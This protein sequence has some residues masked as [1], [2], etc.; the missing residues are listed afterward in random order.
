M[1]KKIEIIHDM[2]G[3][4]RVVGDEHL[5]HCPFCNHHKKKMSI[6]FGLNMFK[7]WVCDT[8][9]KN[10]YRLVRQFGTYQQRQ[11]WLQLD[12]RLDISEFDKFFSEVN[13]EVESHTIEPPESFISLCNRHLPRS[14]RKPLDYLKSRGVTQKDVLFWKLGYSTEGRYNGRI[15]G[16]S[17][18]NDGDWNFFVSRTFCGQRQK[19][20]NPRTSKDIIFNLAGVHHLP[21]VSP[22]AWRCLF[23]G[24]QLPGYAVSKGISKNMFKTGYQLAYVLPMQIEFI[25]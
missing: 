24:A 2:L 20:L 19:Y 10:I 6:N 16:P 21:E 13:N 8:R 11:K 3:S 14:S 25:Q 1:Y 17:F 18:N 23:R 4:Y 12:G 5:F 22:N 9:G 15:L 7:C